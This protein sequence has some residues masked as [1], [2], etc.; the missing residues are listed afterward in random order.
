MRPTVL[1]A[2]SRSRAEG[3]GIVYFGNHRSSLFL[4]KETKI[5]IE[6]FSKSL[7]V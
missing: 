4:V 6:L 1:S 7:A 3:G 5:F 2:D